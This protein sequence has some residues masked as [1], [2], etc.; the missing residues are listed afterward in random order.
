MQVALHAFTGSRKRPRGLGG[1]AAELVDA[2][3]DGIAFVDQ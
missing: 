1:R 3:D 2:G